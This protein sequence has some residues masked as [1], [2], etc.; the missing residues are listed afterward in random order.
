MSMVLARNVTIL[1]ISILSSKAILR[2]KK[3]RFHKKRFSNITYFVEI[4][5]EVY[6]IPIYMYSVGLKDKAKQLIFVLY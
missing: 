6:T 5:N 2:S 1:F 3:Y 4:K